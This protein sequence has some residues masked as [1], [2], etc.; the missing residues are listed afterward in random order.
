MDVSYDPVI[1]QLGSDYTNAGVD[2]G[3]GYRMT[4]KSQLQFAVFAN[5]FESDNNLNET[6]SFG[7]RIGIN[8]NITERS[9][10][11]AQVGYQ[12]FN[13]ETGA[14]PVVETKTDAFLWNV[15][16]SRRWTSSQVRLQAGYSVTPSSA[17]FVTKRRRARASFSH[18][19]GPRFDAR[20]AAIFLETETL[21]DVSDSLNRDFLRA[22]LTLAYELSRKWSLE[23]EVGL[24][25]QDDLN[26]PGDAQSTS[27]GI[28]LVY[29]P[30]I[31]NR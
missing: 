30:P 18:R 5:Q 4:E 29:R 20:I 6:S 15:G 23:A 27:A 24:T 31:Q 25:D 14:N 16:L 7:A 19:F 10:V 1:P 22:T 26:D 3:I 28:S 11:Y 9:S 2:T 8:H 21:G 13:S 12:D 17:G